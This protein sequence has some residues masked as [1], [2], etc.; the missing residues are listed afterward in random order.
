MILPGLGDRIVARE[1]YG[2]QM[3]KE[4]ARPWRP[5]NLFAPVARDPGAH[6]RFDS[7]A[8]GRVTGFNPRWLRAFNIAMASLLVLSMYPIAL[9]LLS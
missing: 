9:H 5:D 3:G 8:R 4:L 1:A 7:E 2:G 6:G